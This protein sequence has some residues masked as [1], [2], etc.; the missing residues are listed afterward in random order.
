[1][2]APVVYGTPSNTTLMANLHYHDLRYIT[3]GYI[4]PDSHV[5]THWPANASFLLSRKDK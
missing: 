5:C 4:D 1:M 2:T 3:E